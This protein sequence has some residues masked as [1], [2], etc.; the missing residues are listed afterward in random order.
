MSS[1]DKKSRKRTGIKEQMRAAKK[2]AKASKLG[3]KG[4]DT[5]SSPTNNDSNNGSLSDKIK[6]LESRVAALEQQNKRLLAIFA[7]T[8]AQLSGGA[9]PDTPI[10]SGN[11]A[12]N[13]VGNGVISNDNDNK[14]DEKGAEAVEETA[15]LTKKSLRWMFQSDH[16]VIINGDNGSSAQKPKYKSGTV[17]FGKPVGPYKDGDRLQKYSVTFDTN[18]TGIY[19]YTI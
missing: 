3:V 13:T 6:S 15:S 4:D 8:F 10:I 14:D 18:S 17:R 19:C 11:G 2:K 12:G 1:K 9:V 7:K 16:K 5:P